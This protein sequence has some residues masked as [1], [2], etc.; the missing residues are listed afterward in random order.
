ML[1]GGAGGWAGAARSSKDR[2]VKTGKGVSDV[3]AGCPGDARSESRNGL[4]TPVG[5]EARGSKDL[6]APAVWGGFGDS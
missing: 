5:V 4:E 3:E 6:S 1:A 2:G